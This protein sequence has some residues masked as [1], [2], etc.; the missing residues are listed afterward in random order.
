MNIVCPNPLTENHPYKKK[1]VTIP[2]VVFV[3][4]AGKVKQQQFHEPSSTSSLK[5]VFVSR[6]ESTQRRGRAGRVREGFCFRLYT[7]K[8]FKERFSEMGIS[9]I[10]PLKPPKLSPHN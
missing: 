4:D 2:D 3:I 8:R 7:E 9:R 5:E 1:G 10:Q 6:A